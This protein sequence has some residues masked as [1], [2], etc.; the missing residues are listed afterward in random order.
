MLLSMPSTRMP[1]TSPGSLHGQT[2]T[3][4]IEAE[5]LAQG[6]GPAHSGNQRPMFNWAAM[7]GTALGV[8]PFN[9]GKTIRTRLQQIYRASSLWIWRGQ[10][11][12]ETIRKSLTVQSFRSSF[13]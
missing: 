2:R 6:A 9:A 10:A 8:Y 12:S 5:D 4:A 3:E 1:R 11:Q 7:A 13:L